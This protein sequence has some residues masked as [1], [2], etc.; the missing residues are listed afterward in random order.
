MELKSS[1]LSRLMSL[2]AYRAGREHIYPSD[3]SLRWFI[4]VQRGRLLAKSAL[5]VLN[6]RLMV[7]PDSFDQAVIEAGHSSVREAA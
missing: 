1:P 4:R 3:T 6:G 2:E 7:D 5:L